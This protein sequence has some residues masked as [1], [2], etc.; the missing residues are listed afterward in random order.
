MFLLQSCVQILYLFICLFIC[1]VKLIVYFKSVSLSL[2]GAALLFERCEMF[3]QQL[4]NASNEDLNERVQ[5]FIERHRRSNRPLLT[6]EPEVDN[7]VST[8]PCVF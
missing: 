1:Q 6:D 7:L 8:F 5:E 4:T 2:S 3:T